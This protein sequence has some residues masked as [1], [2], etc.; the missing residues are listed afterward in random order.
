[1]CAYL[2]QIDKYLYVYAR[3]MCIFIT[4]DTHLHGIQGIRTLLLHTQ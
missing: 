2:K 1:M 4:N 3:K